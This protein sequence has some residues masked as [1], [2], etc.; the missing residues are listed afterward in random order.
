[1]GHRPSLGCGALV[2]LC[3][4]WA[5]AG[6]ASETLSPVSQNPMG[7][8]PDGVIW[9]P[10]GRFLAHGGTGVTVWDVETGRIRA[11]F[12]AE[13]AAREV[14]WSPD[15]DRVSALL[16]H[17]EVVRE[18]TVR[19][20]QAEEIPSQKRY[21]GRPRVE[22]SPDGTRHVIV[23]TQAV[24]HDSTTG[25]ELA[26]FPAS[27]ASFGP[28]GRRLVVA[29]RWSATLVDGRSGEELCTLGPVLEP[30]MEG[31]RWNHV[32][33][34]W[35]LEGGRVALWD[36]SP[37]REESTRILIFDGR[38]GEEISSLVFPPQTLRAVEFDGDPERLY[39][40]GNGR[41]DVWQL[42]AG[43]RT[44]LVEGEDIRDV[45]WDRIRGRV[46][47]LHAPREGP[48]FTPPDPERD[49]SRIDVW[50][51]ETGEHATLPGT[52]TCIA[53]SGGLRWSPDGG[54]LARWCQ[55]GRIVLWEFEA[56]ASHRVLGQNG[57]QTA[58][59]RFSPDGSR[60]AVVAD[61]NRVLV[62]DL[63]EGALLGVRDV[64]PDLV[65]DLAWS[66][67]GRLLAIGTPVVVVWDPA[68]DVVLHELDLS[69]P[70]ASLDATT[71]RGEKW[72][73][74][75]RVLYSPDG[76]YL[77]TVRAWDRTIAVWDAREG[78]LLGVLGP[79]SD[80][81]PSLSGH[82][83][84]IH[85]LAFSPDS[86]WL[87]SASADGAVIGW[88]ATRL[89]APEDLRPVLWAKLRS[90]A[91]SLAWAPGGEQL[92]FLDSRQLVRVLRPADGIPGEIV[93]LDTSVSAMV[94]VSDG[95]PLLMLDKP[96]KHA[97]FPRFVRLDL[98]T[99]EVT[100]GREVPW[101]IHRATFS[102]D[103]E[104][105]AFGGY[106]LTL[107][108]VGDGSSVSLRAARVQDGWATLTTTPDGRFDGDPRLFDQL[109]Y[110]DPS[111]DL[112]QRPLL[113]G[114]EVTDLFHKPG[115]YRSEGFGTA[116]ESP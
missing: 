105:L 61:Y 19:D 43:E 103:C 80:D 72:V 109:I 108:R 93:E 67:D 115:L 8:S 34:S 77:V 110:A 99:S 15:G 91:P 10:D 49:L 78:A 53:A 42:P 9:S 13:D 95:G 64:G 58:R 74:A 46:A 4:L 57:W 116:A 79:G 60:V 48:M 104:L 1:M 50:E 51:P 97:R 30:W 12:G 62:W 68:R 82:L 39:S 70:P 114:S 22:Y 88:D 45:A 31:D 28:D 85:K 11:R 102:T 47:V 106:G 69:E 35:S 55:P 27:A 90:L 98:V 56:E 101:R 41:I 87:A 52:G 36:F 111:A 84:E 100:T 40:W 2:C 107:L 112:L 37:R 6:S 73:R 66:P 14:R 17:E 3:I 33:V 59:S 75:R 29:S 113:P 24:L 86:R 92:A 38:T 83:R 96:P 81:D 20:G 23:E 89:R 32:Q 65:G 7:I 21:R 71:H 16:M 94:L 26:R 63:A 76:E 25:A 54:T 44:A 18:W 5:W